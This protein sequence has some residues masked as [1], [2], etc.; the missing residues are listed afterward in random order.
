MIYPAKIP[1]ETEEKVKSFMIIMSLE[2]FT[3]VNPIEVTK[4]MRIHAIKFMDVNKGETEF[5]EQEH[6]F[7]TPRMLLL[8]FSGTKFLIYG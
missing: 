2:D 5:F 8:N 3:R 1:Y 4:A 6:L 7:F